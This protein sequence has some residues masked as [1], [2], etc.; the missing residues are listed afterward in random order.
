MTLSK[1]ST[2]RI[3]TEGC[4]ARQFE[5]DISQTVCSGVAR[6]DAVGEIKVAVS[7]CV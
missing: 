5:S 6:G 2:V 7:D 3:D 4:K 1:A